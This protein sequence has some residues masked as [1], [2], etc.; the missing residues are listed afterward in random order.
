M[1]QPN[2]LTSY[3]ETTHYVYVSRSC[4]YKSVSYSTDIKTINLN[5]YI[6]IYTNMRVHIYA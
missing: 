5:V 2:L 6:Y 1:L 3:E 4:R